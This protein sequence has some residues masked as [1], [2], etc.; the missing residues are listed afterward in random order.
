M[1][2]DVSVDEPPE[3]DDELLAVPQ[4]ASTSTRQI[5]MTS[6]RFFFN[7]GSHILLEHLWDV[8]IVFVKKRSLASY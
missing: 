4:A 7:M 8:I 2:V 1:L 3:A 6:I 5:L